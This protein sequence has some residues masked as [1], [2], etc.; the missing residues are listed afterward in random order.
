MRACVG[1]CDATNSANRTWTH[2]NGN[3]VPECDFLDPVA[4]GECD[5]SVNPAHFDPYRVSAPLDSRLPDGG[6]Y[7]ICGLY[8]EEV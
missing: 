6:G 8:K 2:H 4:N 1:L 7:P 5:R 3:F